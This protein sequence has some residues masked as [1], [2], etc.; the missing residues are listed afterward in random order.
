MAQH[1]FH[2]TAEWN[3][4]R[5][6]EGT[7]RAGNLDTKISIPKE[8]G[9]PGVGTNPDEMLIG[10]AAT[11]YLITLAA[12]LERKQIPV[13]K[14]TLETTG[15]VSENRG[16]LKFE[17]ITHYPHVVLGTEV[18]EQQV[19]EAKGFTEKAEQSCM[20]SNALRGNVEL[21]VEARVEKA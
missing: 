17:S 19:E 11:C 18:T 1:E 14:L 21:A 8:M 12:M 3:G 5:N 13:D 20:I 15:V 10:A 7:I 9:G 6:A 2:L 4:G 16:R